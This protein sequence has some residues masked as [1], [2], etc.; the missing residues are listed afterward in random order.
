MEEL[1][2]KIKADFLKVLAHPLRLQI[3][4]FLKNGEQKVGTIAKKIGIP[5]SSLSRHLLFL[6][7]GGVLRSRQVGTVI[8][9]GIESQDIFKVLRPIAE[10]LR[11]KLKKTEKVLDSLG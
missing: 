6:K 10:M 5:Q 3:I 11:Q 7:E 4:E 9:Y 8:F 2:Y 1:A